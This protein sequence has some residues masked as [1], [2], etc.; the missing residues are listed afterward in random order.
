MSLII[1]FS[2][3]VFYLQSLSCLVIDKVALILPTALSASVHSLAYFNCAVNFQSFSPNFLCAILAQ[4]GSTNYCILFVFKA[5][6]VWSNEIHPKNWSP[7]PFPICFNCPPFHRASFSRSS[8]PIY[9]LQLLRTICFPNFSQHTH[10][11]PLKTPLC[12]PLPV[13]IT[14]LFLKASSSYLNKGVQVIGVLYQF[15]WKRFDWSKK[16]GVLDTKVTS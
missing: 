7:A 4:I 2:L 13:S 14:Q 11:P 16:T 15:F 10:A 6:C 5:C 1:I 9:S 3:A 12:P 8:G